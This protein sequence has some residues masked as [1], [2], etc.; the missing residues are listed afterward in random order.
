MIS[1]SLIPFAKGNPTV[2]LAI[3]I[4][5]TKLYEF[6][7]SESC[8]HS[9]FSQKIY[10]NS[11]KMQSFLPGDLSPGN[12][13]QTLPALSIGSFEYVKQLRNLKFSVRKI[14]NIQGSV[15]SS[16]ESRAVVYCAF[17]QSLINN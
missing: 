3:I 16:C 6:S 4:H 14:T 15:L 11:L 2:I 10:R 17:K 8:D 13:H 1:F 12:P 9:M 7:I 5:C